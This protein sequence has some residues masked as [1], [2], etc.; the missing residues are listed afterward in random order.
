MES[1]SRGGS[2]F[3]LF[4]KNKEV[5]YGQGA[6]SHLCGNIAQIDMHLRSEETGNKHGNA[7]KVCGKV[8]Y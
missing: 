5:N 8:D 4:I 1:V 6:N 2:I 7:C 3:Q